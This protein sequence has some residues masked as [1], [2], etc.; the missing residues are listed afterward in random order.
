LTNRKH[1]DEA[2]TELVTTM[3]WV[4]SEDERTERNFSLE[5]SLEFGESKLRRVGHVGLW[6]RA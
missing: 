5:L 3:F 2:L 4:A 1:G 6:L